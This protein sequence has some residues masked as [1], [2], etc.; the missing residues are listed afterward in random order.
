MHLFDCLLPEYAFSDYYIVCTKLSLF[1]L[2][3]SSMTNQMTISKRRVHLQKNTQSITSF[4]M[5]S[6]IE[7]SSLI[8]QLT[9]HPSDN[10]KKDISQLSCMERRGK[11]TI[12]Q[13]KEHIK[14]VYAKI[15]IT[16]T[17]K[18]KG[19]IKRT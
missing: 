14:H 11:H 17:E 3:A 15:R 7:I 16:D 19:I 6:I 10:R 9:T 5:L 13:G 1:S 2:G 18:M 8:F 12:M 4:P